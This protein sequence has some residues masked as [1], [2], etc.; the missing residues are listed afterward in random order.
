MPVVPVKQNAVVPVASPKKVET[1]KAPANKAA[2]KKT[3]VP[4]KAQDARNEKRVEI[5]AYEIKR[6][7]ATLRR[8]DDTIQNTP[9]EQGKQLALLKNRR[10]MTLLNIKAIEQELSR[11]GFRVSNSSN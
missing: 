8:I 9:A 5:L 3:I 2:V 6:E 10:K 11:L 1:P 7:L 4:T